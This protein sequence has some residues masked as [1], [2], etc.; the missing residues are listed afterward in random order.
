MAVRRDIVERVGVFDER[1][2]AGTPTRSGGD[3][4]M[5]ARILAAGYRIVYDPAAVSWH[6]HRRTYDEV[7]DTVYGYGV[8]VYAM[9]TGMLI[10]RR[11]LGVLRIAWS[12]FRS[13][14]LPAL[15]GMAL[16]RPSESKRR[17]ALAELRGCLN[18]P[19]AW[20]EAERGRRLRA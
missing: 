11:E 12:W 9:W 13:A 6:R 2:D 4:E 16:R 1:L 3:H 7:L 17:L 18:G 14:H 8:G 19:R 15:I 10:E 20:F 5:F